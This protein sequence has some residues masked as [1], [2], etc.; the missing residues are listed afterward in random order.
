MTDRCTLAIVATVLALATPGAWSQAYPARVVRVASTQ[1]AGS[2]ADVLLRLSAQKISESIAQ[3]VVV[4][5]QAGAAGVLAAQ[6]V[7]R[8][9]PDGYTVLYTLVNTI[10]TTPQLMKAKPFDLKDFTPLIVVAA[11][12][13]CMVAATNF[14]PNTITE[15]VQAARA[16][17][18]KLA[19]GTNGLGGTYHLDMALLSQ[20]F[21]LD[22]IHVPYKSGVDALMAA[23][24]ATLPI[25][26]APCASAFPQVKAGKLKVIAALEKARLPELPD[27][28][29][30]GEWIP[31]YEK[32]A[33]GVD[34]YGPAGLPQ[35]IAARLASEMQKALATPE[36]RA[37]MRDIAFFPVGLMLEE[38]G[39]QRRK[40]IGVVAIAIKAA[41]L[42]AE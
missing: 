4:E 1:T 14:A 27:L 10:V 6:T 30:M 22:L 29:A 33:S 21:G 7:A 9:A 18:G 2:P 34:L 19:Y 25:A 13:T 26:Y 12:V 5:V 28:P 15:V 37:R 16:N 40:D 23:T 39:A 38:M 32:V 8:A 31:D 20:K 35:A 3:P 42:K 17:P 24:T 11:A 41:G 36:V